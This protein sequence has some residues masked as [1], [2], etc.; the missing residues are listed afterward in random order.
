MQYLLFNSILRSLSYAFTAQ[1]NISQ[2]NFIFLEVY[3]VFCFLFLKCL[4]LAKQA[5]E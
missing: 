4:V 1:V 3:E 2:I 5:I